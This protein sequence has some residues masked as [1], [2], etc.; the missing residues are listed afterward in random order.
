MPWAR[1]QLNGPMVAGVSGRASAEF[2]FQGIDACLGVNGIPQSA[3][4]QT[5]LFTGVNAS[6]LLGYHLP[7][8]PNERLAQVIQEHSIFKRI[9]Q[10]GHQV[11]F[12]NAYR[13][14]YFAWAEKQRRPHSASTLSIGAAAVPFRTL[15]DLQK[16]EALCW[17]I[18]NEFLQ[19]T[20][21]YAVPVVSGEI[22][23]QRL[24]EL[25][26]THD[27]V[28]YESFKTD[29]LG[30]RRNLAASIDFLN[31]IDAF[32]QSVVQHRPA[33]T[34]VLITSDHGN[35]ED[36]STGNH[37]RNQVP[38]WVFGPLAEPMKDARSIIDVPKCL[39]DYFA[40]DSARHSP[41]QSTEPR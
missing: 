37:T 29:L 22:A 2:L 40:R 23:G 8:F 21:E 20:P 38:L 31:I 33:G 28:L 27:L 34:S 14:D 41:N 15:A 4:G 39:V 10:L 12:A 25:T 17:D 1:Q 35:I 11:T 5:T 9:A 24:G 18:T 3:T 26:R 19:A 36:L 30:H 13:P 6:Q 32:L 7:A 16:G